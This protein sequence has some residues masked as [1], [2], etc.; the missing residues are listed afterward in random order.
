MTLLVNASRRQTLFPSNVG[1]GVIGTYRQR[2]DEVITYCIDYSS[3]LNDDE[4]LASATFEAS[5][6]AE[7]LVTISGYEIEDDKK[8]LFQISGGLDDNKYA[9][10]VETTTETD[11]VKIDVFYVSV[12]TQDA[13]LNFPAVDSLVSQAQTYRNEAQTAATNAATSATAAASSATSAAASASSVGASAASATASAATATTKASEAAASA[14]AASTSATTATTKA[15]EAASSASSASTS[16]TTATTKASEAATSASNAATSATTATT[17]ATEASTSATAAAASATTANTAA[18]NAA[19]SLASANTA[20]TAAQ[21]AQAAAE[22]ARDAT[23][24]AYDS[25]DDR[26][27]GAKASDPSVDNDGNA[28]VG[29]SLYFNTTDSVMKVYTGTAWVAAYVS[30]TSTGTLLAANNLGDLTNAATARNN[31]GLGSAATRSDTYFATAAQVN[32]IPDPVA[33]ALVFGS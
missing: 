20:K 7:T 25:F 9:I 4:S 24:A 13:N 32:A 3:W 18:N 15:S 33:M 17:K 5:S 23:L 19:T 21:T 14:S 1:G 16:A 30:G 28:L 12:G 8:L 11:Q 10:T 29:G 6:G 26:Y 31:L 27:L 22:S 2:N